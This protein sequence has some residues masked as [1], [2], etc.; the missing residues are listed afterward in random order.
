M[1][2][3]EPRLQAQAR[4]L[5]ELAGALAGMSSI[6]LLLAFQGRP[7]LS[8]PGALLAAG[9]MAAWAVP[10]LSMRLLLAVVWVASR[11]A[12]PLQQVPPMAVAAVAGLAEMSSWSRGKLEALA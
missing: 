1:A 4:W 12:L 5:S 2:E 6:A 8:A 3:V 7:S 10:P 11:Q 9:R